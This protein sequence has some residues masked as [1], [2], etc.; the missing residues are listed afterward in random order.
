[1]RVLRCTRYYLWRH[2]RMPQQRL[3]GDQWKGS[4]RWQRLTAGIAN[5]IAV[6]V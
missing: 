6:V 3:Y 1:M 2:M 5:G 4:R